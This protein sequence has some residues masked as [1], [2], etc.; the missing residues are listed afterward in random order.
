MK[1]VILPTFTVASCS[2]R[3]AGQSHRFILP[4]TLQLG[5][6]MDK[7]IDSGYSM[8]PQLLVALIPVSGLVPAALICICAGPPSTRQGQG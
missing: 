7:K 8:I 6:V 4:A 3:I 1:P 2:T 5:H